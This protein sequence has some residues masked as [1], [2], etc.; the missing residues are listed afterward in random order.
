[1]TG[2]VAE[3]RNLFEEIRKAIDYGPRYQYREQREWYQLAK[4]QLAA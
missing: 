2:R 4:R 3:A 1:M